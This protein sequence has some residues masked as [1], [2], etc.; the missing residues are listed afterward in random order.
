MS[1]L[2]HL[3][4]Q[5]YA[6]R[7]H[8]FCQ[9]PELIAL[10]QR[11]QF[12]K[13]VRVLAIGKAAWKMASLCGKYLNDQGLGCDGFVLT[14][15]GHSHGLI[16]GLKI[17]EAG[18]PLP[19]DNS[20]KHSTAIVKWL[21]N[22]PADDT[23]IVL[24]SGGGSALFEV[25]PKGV[26]L[27]DINTNNQ[28]LLRSGQTI[29]EINAERSR[30]SLVKAGQA[31]NYTKSQNIHV[32]AVSDVAGDDPHT[33]CSGPFTP[34]Q[35]GKRT[36]SGWIYEAG[37]KH[38]HYQIVADNH[39]F[40]RELG[41]D[42]KQQGFKVRLDDA[43]Y[44]CSLPKFTS[45]LKAIL[46]KAFSPRYKL[47]PPFIYILGGEI[48]LQVRGSGKG[49]RCSHLALSLAYTLGKYR[50]TALF[51]FATDG[52]D[53][54]TGSGGAFVDTDT[55]KAL[56]KEGIGISPSLKSCDSFTALKAI[57]QILP[58]PILA[59]NVNDVFILSVGYSFENP[60][61]N[62]SDGGPDIFDGMF[63]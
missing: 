37:S 17:L 42:L 16:P 56:F 21:K 13:Q 46:E 48:P 19:D 22:L 53:N 30:N 54:V 6:Q 40:C 25:L 9:Y 8:L 29:A 58:S 4:Y 31:L 59:T 50:D 15:Y 49:G 3:I 12:G 7:M 63:G 57:H 23:L 20:L 28:I 18:H 1:C 62:C 2:H 27:Q 52:N 34:T 43:Y 32:F 5:S 61:A 51:C 60:L 11:T 33:I 14:K 41:L 35:L 44:N 55:R 10:L 38:I 39:S 26:S 36:D 47:K 24:L 45:Q